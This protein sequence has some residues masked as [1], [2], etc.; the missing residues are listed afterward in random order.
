MRGLLKVCLVL[1]AIA[2][3]TGTM[4]YYAKTRLDPPRAVVE[5]RVHADHVRSSI[6]L[7]GQAYGVD[8]LRE[9]FFTCNHLI[10][11]LDDN[12]LLSIEESDSLKSQMVGKY[13]PAYADWCLRCFQAPTWYADDLRKMNSDIK[14]IRGIRRADKT[15]IAP[16]GSRQGERIDSVA[17][18]LNRYESAKSLVRRGEGMTYESIT[19]SEKRIHRA[20][21]YRRDPYLKNNVTLVNALDSV[22]YWLEKAHYAQLEKWVDNMANCTYMDEEEYDQQHN[23]VM[24]RI[25]N[26]EESAYGVY[27]RSHSVKPLRS[28]MENLRDDYVA[29]KSSFS[30]SIG[31]VDFRF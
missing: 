11:F 23:R 19:D 18:I 21:A 2:L 20:K 27:G 6:E 28:R 9:R 29:K 31:G 30:I 22:P 13:I 15:A 16:K 4:L 8:K 26:Y 17:A 3:A 1:L 14:R 10:G 5:T 24:E 7:I 12:N 25:D